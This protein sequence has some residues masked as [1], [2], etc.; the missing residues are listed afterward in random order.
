MIINTT[1]F[2]MKVVLKR[3]KQQQKSLAYNSAEMFK[4][5]SDIQPR[6]YKSKDSFTKRE[7]EREAIS[8][9]S[10]FFFFEYAPFHVKY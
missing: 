7:S 8:S 9:S 3:K 4:S 5:V 2:N 1:G 6:F 10:F